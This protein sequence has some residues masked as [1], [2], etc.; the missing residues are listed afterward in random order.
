MRASAKAV[1]ETTAALRSELGE[2][3]ASN[4]ELKRELKA[5]AAQLQDLRD[6]QQQL[7]P[8]SMV[9]KITPL[10]LSLVRCPAAFFLLTSSLRVP[11]R[12]ACF[13]PSL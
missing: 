6:A 9:S 12:P 11:P 3:K 8:K 7:A 5:T 2:V 13:L 4:D 1:S 10:A